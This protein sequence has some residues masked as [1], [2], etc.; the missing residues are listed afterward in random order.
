MQSVQSFTIG[1]AYC[2]PVI[3]SVLQTFGQTV[4]PVVNL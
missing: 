4:V 1:V 2:G 3:L